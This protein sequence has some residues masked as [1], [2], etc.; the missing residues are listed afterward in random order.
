MR[1][2]R[3]IVQECLERAQGE[4]GRI[5]CYKIFLSDSISY[6]RYEYENG[7]FVEEASGDRGEVY[8]SV[9]GHSEEEFV[10]YLIYGAVKR[11]AFRYECEHRRK[12]EDNRRQV[13]EIIERCYSY[14][15]KSYKYDLMVQ[16]K[17]NIHIYFDLLDYYV[18]ISKEYLEKQP[19]YGDVKGSF[20]FIARKRYA[21][22]G[23]GMYDVA[24]SFEWVR[25]HISKIV[26]VFPRLGK[27]YFF[28]EEQ[29]QRLVAIEK[30]EPYS[31]ERYQLGGWD[32][33]IFEKAECILQGRQIQDAEALSCAAYMLIVM[34]HTKRDVV[35]DIEALIRLSKQVD[36][37]P[38]KQALEELF[39]T[40]KYGIFR[41]E[42]YSEYKE[43]GRKALGL[44]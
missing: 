9:V 30:S 4:L 11:F 21:N 16:L 20:E 23:G 1:D 33:S 43:Y 35:K 32:F 28:Y 34:I 24:F 10:E 37:T 3:M 39:V 25:Y 2:G 7:E 5:A 14:L 41:R 31:A 15:G 17:D 18:R 29:Y 8:R 40:D 19:V 12:F 26:A 38:Y 42:S 22:K 13:N 44:E 27:D 36:V 6:N